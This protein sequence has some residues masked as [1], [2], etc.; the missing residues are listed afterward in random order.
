MKKYLVGLFLS[1]FLVSTAFSEEAGLIKVKVNLFDGGQ[2]SSDLAD[3]IESSQGVSVKNAVITKKGQLSKRK[4]EALFANDVGSTA[5]TG[6][7]L[8]VPDVNTKFV[9]VASGVSVARTGIT[10]A[11]W[12]VVN[13]SNNLTAGKDTEFVQANNLLFILNGY[14]NT[15]WYTGSLWTPSTG[16]ATSPPVATTAI[17][18]R[19]YMFYAGNSTYPDW[20]YFSNNLAPQ[21]MTPTDIIKVNTGDGQKIVKLEPFKLN[22]LIV[23]KERSIFIID[24]SGAVL[25]GWTV[26]PVTTVI[27]CI[28]PRSVVNVGNDH[29]FLSSDPIAVRSLV[30]SQYDKILV[31]ML[32][33][34]IQDLFDGTGEV[35]IN[36]TYVNKACAVLFDNKY[37][38]A[39]PTGTSSYND[40]VIVFD[41]V[42]KSWFHITGWYPSSWVVVN[43]R[44]FYTD[45]STGQMVE[46][47]TGSTGD[48][49]SN[50]T[51]TTAISMEYVSKNI[52]FDNSNNYKGLDAIDFEFDAS[53]N[54]N[55]EAYIELDDSGFQD[56]GSINLKGKG[57]TL[58]ATLPFTLGA[59]G[60]ARKTFQVQKYGEFKKIKVKV[61]QDGLGEECK[62]YSF[63]IYAKMKNWRRE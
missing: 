7:G 2:N 30:R 32:S 34:P 59:S 38:L 19:N 52:D 55:A 9:T 13:P 41:L 27:G 62:L 31:E 16:A 54:Y 49:T 24:I 50:S 56:I 61:V 22:E 35:S 33:T 57:V 48:I 43:N 25:S 4:G 12:V 11:N 8:F 44:L 28:A 15:A 18:L 53:G 36:K 47:L 63:T 10:G 3:V 5:F 6:S 21:T 60:V 37:L 39:I 17:W 51:V 26:Q 58:P 1:L 23:Y 20:V 46:C 45:A 40:Y 29:W 14:D 42:T